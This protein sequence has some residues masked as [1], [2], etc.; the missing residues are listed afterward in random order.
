MTRARRSKKTYTIISGSTRKDA[1]SSKVARHVAAQLESIDK[2]AAVELVDLSRVALQSWHEGFWDDKATPDANWAKVSASLRRSD[3]LIFVT[4]EWNGMVPPALLNVFL[5]A[6]RGELAHRPALIVAVSASGGGSAPVLELRA[7]G[8][9]NTQVCY[10]PD[11][12]IVRN[13]RSVLN[14]PGAQSDADQMVRDRIVYSLRV[15]SVYASAFEAIRKSG[16]IDLET[17]PY[18]M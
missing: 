4:P 10:I 18:G 14:G 13:A 9:K 2:D 8:G 17:Y 15:L 11:H 3:G 16:V 12:V 5:L 7:F 1:Q 6:S